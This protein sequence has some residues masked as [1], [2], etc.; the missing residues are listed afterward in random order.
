MYIKTSWVARIIDTFTTLML[1][2][3]QA[4][5]DI[6]S[7]VKTCSLLPKVRSMHPSFLVV[8]LNNGSIFGRFSWA[9]TLLEILRTS[10]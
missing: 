10:L 7:V 8:S 5:S 4:F 6:F 1:N 3:F 2:V 9:S